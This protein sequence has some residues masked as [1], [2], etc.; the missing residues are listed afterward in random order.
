M[1]YKQ[2]FSLDLRLH[3]E[4]YRDY[5]LLLVP[6]LPGF[7]VSDE[8]QVL[9]AGKAVEESAIRKLLDEKEAGK[10]PDKTF[11]A[12]VWKLARAF[13]KRRAEGFLKNNRSHQIIVCLKQA[14]G[15]RRSLRRGGLQGDVQP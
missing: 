14:Q 5:A 4:V 13:G 1:V 2:P 6:N 15:R 3:G 10:V 11:S 9:V 7:R 12:G 8:K